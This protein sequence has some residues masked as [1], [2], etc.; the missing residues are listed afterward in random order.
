[1]HSVLD[2]ILTSLETVTSS[3][4]PTQEIAESVETFSELDVALNENTTA[5]EVAMKQVLL[6]LFDDLCYL[7]E[8]SVLG[9]LMLGMAN[10]MA[11][12]LVFMSKKM[13]LRL[14]NCLMSVK[15]N[16]RGKPIA[17]LPVITACKVKCI[18]GNYTLFRVF[19]V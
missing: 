8:Q 12:R 6:P 14:R 9:C 1:M 5:S 19:N 2:S 11:C 17:K 3:L 7:Q 4:V 18:F 15:N 10:Q 16:T 13:C